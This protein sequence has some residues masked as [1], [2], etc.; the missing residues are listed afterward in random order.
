VQFPAYVSFSWSASNVNQVF[1]GIDTNDASAAPFFDN[2]PPSGD[3]SD[4]PSGYDPFQ[5]G[6]YSASHKYTLTVI[7]SDGSKVSKSITITNTGDV[8]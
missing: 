1:F 7:G 8:Q 6:C 2:L 5:Y 4:F 3:T